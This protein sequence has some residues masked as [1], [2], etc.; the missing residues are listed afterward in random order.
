MKMNWMLLASAP[1]KERMIKI[2]SGYFYSSNIELI[3]FSDGIFVVAT[4]KGA[5]E[6]FRVIQK[7][8]RFRFEQ[9]LDS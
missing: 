3:P 4:A 5:L 7:G 8:K 1:T 2:I 9:R 6:K